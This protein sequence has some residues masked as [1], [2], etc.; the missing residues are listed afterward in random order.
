MPKYKYKYKSKATNNYKKKGK[1]QVA[2]NTKA[3]RHLNDTQYRKCS[4]IEQYQKGPA[5]VNQPDTGLKRI[6]VKQ[7][8]VPNQWIPVFGSQ[9]LLSADREVMKV[10]HPTNFSVSGLNIRVNLRL[11]GFHIGNA[12]YPIQY[13]YF[14][15]SIKREY[16][17]QV[18]FR[19]S[20]APG[21]P[22][23]CTNS[24]LQHLRKGEDFECFDVKI[25]VSA[26]QPPLTPPFA[27]WRMNKEY[28]TVHASRKGIIG[29]WPAPLPL[30]GSGAQAANHKFVT[31]ASMKDANKEFSVNIKWKRNL[32]HTGFSES[33]DPLATVPQRNSWKNMNAEQVSDSDQ[34]YR[35]LF[36]NAY[37]ETGS[38]LVIAESME[39][40]GKEPQ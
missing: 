38:P 31:V 29:V 14:I 28:Y 40:F 39:F 16:R 4:Y 19:T 23:L 8:I 9:P 2:K 18:K 26:P 32:K 12:T 13:Q 10:S 37:S 3:I 22:D 33:L 15:F 21:S 24:Q 7:L 6:E 27:Q 1:S 34:L 5:V 17:E 11:D 25:P 30:V 36:H 35:V 20:R